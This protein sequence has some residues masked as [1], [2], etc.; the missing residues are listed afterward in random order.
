[1]KKD[2]SRMYGSIES[3]KFINGV[4][5]FCSIV[6]EHQVRTGGVSFYFPCVKC[7]NVSKVVSVDILREHILLCGFR[8]QYQVRVWHGE[9]RV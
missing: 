3:S 7:D 4:L 8:P 2:R 1:M 6:V 9:E 5:E